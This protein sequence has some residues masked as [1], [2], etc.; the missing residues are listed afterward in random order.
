MRAMPKSLLIHAVARVKT[1]PVDF[2]ENEE[3]SDREEITFVRME[4][5]HRIIRDKNNAEVQLSAVLFYDC[6]NSRPRGMEFFEDEVI[7]FGGQSYR[8]IEVEPL[9]DGRRLHHYEIGMVKRA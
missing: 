5:S 3:I 4:P 7:L 8:V 9:Y 2:W 1:A 6:R